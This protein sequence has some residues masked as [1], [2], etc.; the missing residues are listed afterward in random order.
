MINVHDCICQMIKYTFVERLSC[1]FIINIFLYA[2]ATG[3]L[4]YGVLTS[5]KTGIYHADKISMPAKLP[6]FSLCQ[7]FR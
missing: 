4:G 7:L 1:L 2:I 3:I 5:K 6:Q